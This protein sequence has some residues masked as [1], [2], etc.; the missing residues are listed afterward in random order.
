MEEPILKTV[1]VTKIYNQGK[2]NE[3]V[4][5]R[6][7]SLSVEKG[8]A[9][10][11]KGPSGSGKTTLLSMI[12]CQIK[13]TYG[14]IVV[15]GKQ[16][17]KLPEKFANLHKREHIGFVFQ[18]FHLIPDLSVLDN[19]MLPLLPSGIRPSER[20]RRAGKLLEE[21]ELVPRMQFKVKDLSGGEQQRVAISRS[22]INGCTVLLADEP[23]AHLDG[24]LT[25]DFLSH[26]MDLKQRGY[27][28][29]IASHDPIVFKN[30]L[31][32][33]IV[34]MKSGEIIS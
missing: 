15:N 17:S 4:P 6:D 9:V 34:D 1:K 28:I 30:E 7:A 29:L 5:V 21:Y 31:V 12:G 32:D 25:A 10:V 27:T 14:E 3:V 8:T 26:M 24:Q 22:L 23:T 18:Q 13:P 33:R 20:K 2:H 16:V 19:I 11:L